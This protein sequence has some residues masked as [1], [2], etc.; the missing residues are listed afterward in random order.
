MNSKVSYFIKC[1]LQDIRFEKISSFM[2]ILK[3]KEKI[4][5]LLI[6]HLVIGSQNKF[7]EIRK[8]QK[9]FEGYLKVDSHVEPLGGLG[10]QE[11]V[12]NG[13]LVTT[14]SCHSGCQCN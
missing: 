14:N 7:S 13:Y 8:G 9:S 2:L 11:S 10:G 5:F 4:G 3:F 1:V 6:H 12:L